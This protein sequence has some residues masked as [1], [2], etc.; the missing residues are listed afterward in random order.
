VQ[1]LARVGHRAETSK[2][3]SPS[4]YNKGGDHST[5][6]KSMR[7]ED[8]SLFC[9]WCNKRA[10]DVS[11]DHI[12]PRVLGGTRELW[13]PACYGC[14]NL[15]SKFEQEVGRSSPYSGFLLEQGPKPRDKRKPKSGFLRT[16]YCLVKHPLGGYGEASLRVG[17]ETPRA[18]PHLE[19]DIFSKQMRRRGSR[20]EDVDHLVEVLLEIAGRV[21]GAE[22]LA[23]QFFARTENIP[24]IS[25]DPDFW[26]RV[27]LDVSDR[28]FIRARD[29]TEAR[30][31]AELLMT[32]LRAG[33]CR[34][35]SRWTNAE[36]SGGTP[37]VVQLCCRE[38]SL[39]RLAAKV[40]F[41]LSWLRSSEVRSQMEILSPVRELVLGHSVRNSRLDVRWIS[42]PNSI[43]VFPDYHAALVR[44]LH[45]RLQ[46]LVSVYGDCSVVELTIPVESLVGFETIAAISRRDGTRTEIV[47]GGAMEAIAMAFEEHVTRSMV[48]E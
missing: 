37:H 46:G 42:K 29:G 44:R 7:Q 18:L 17:D 3:L 38:S 2:A 32:F 36:I 25:G 12:F 45:D 47:E 41:G 9:G 22:Q 27:V 26:P 10:T 40:S 11:K 19:I 5:T 16:K 48:T 31:F 20:P 43:R 33:A 23:Q 14:Q 30:L 24:E 6:V 21:S 28:P 39:H 1:P 8:K 15:I 34:D 13:I 4:S 35:Y